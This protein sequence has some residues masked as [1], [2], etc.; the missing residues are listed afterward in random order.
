MSTLKITFN[1]S[2]AIHPLRIFISHE[3]NYGSYVCIIL[4]EEKSLKYIE[5]QN[6]FTGELWDQYKYKSLFVYIFIQNFKKLDNNK[7]LTYNDNKIL[8]FQIKSID[9]LLDF[10]NFIEIQPKYNI[11]IENSE[12]IE[13]SNETPKELNININYESLTNIQQLYIILSISNMFIFIEKTQNLLTFKPKKYYCISNFHFIYKKHHRKSIKFQQITDEKTIN[14][15]GSIYGKKTYKYIVNL[16]LNDYKIGQ[17]FNN[18]FIIY[19]I[20]HNI[21]FNYNKTILYLFSYKEFKFKKTTISFNENPY[22]QYKYDKS[23]F[24]Y[25]IEK[26]NIKQTN[27]YFFSSLY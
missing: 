20:Y 12:L 15:I 3:I 5:I 27:D 23:Q 16:N 2:D 10:N 24:I 14:L 6:I 18:K 1:L 9:K 22:F 8:E 19:K 7:F 25:T 17:K 13:N 26:S 11:F 4:S 21:S